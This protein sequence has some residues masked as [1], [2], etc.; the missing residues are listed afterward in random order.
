MRAAGSVIWFDDEVQLDAVTA[1][2]GSGP[3]YVYYF[4]EAVQQ[5]GRELGL[6]PAQ[7]R[8]L[9]LATFS[10]AIRLAEQSGTAVETLRAEVTSKGG[11]TA[12][13]LEQLDADQVR[14]SIVL[15]VRRAQQRATELGDEFGAA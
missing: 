15:A 9:A 2:S 11:T 8:E 13:A 14:D 7:A 10:G 5:A 12:A 4:I 1:I 3:A 6:A